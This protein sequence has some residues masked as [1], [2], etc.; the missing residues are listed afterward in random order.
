M[1][2]KFNVEEFGPKNK[3]NRKYIASLIMFILL[4]G[5]TIMAYLLISGLGTK[6]EVLTV[7][8]LEEIINISD[9]NT[10]QAVYN[11][12]AEVRDEKN[13]IEC[14]VSY[15]AKINAG[16]DFGKISINKDEEGKKIVI[17]IPKVTLSEIDVSPGSLDYIYLK[18][19]S[20]EELMTKRAFKAC[21][22]DV[23]NESKNEK[24]IYT[25]AEQNAKNIVEALIN[26]FIQQLDSEY[27]VIL[28]GEE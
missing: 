3:T 8:M 18:K 20:D 10:Y 25:L 7:S 19:V 22:E 17:S 16:I 14:Y 11:G 26:P 6:T 23:E 9:L 5:L 13:E 2:D 12:V 15:E 4:I 28:K 1:N 27:E 24:E 21:K